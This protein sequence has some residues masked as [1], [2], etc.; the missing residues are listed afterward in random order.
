MHVHI[1][2]NLHVILCGPETIFTEPTDPSSSSVVLIQHLSTFSP[3][4]ERRPVEFSQFCPKRCLLFGVVLI[5]YSFLYKRVDFS[6]WLYTTKVQP[7]ASQIFYRKD[8]SEGSRGQTIET[9]DHTRKYQWYTN[10]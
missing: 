10:I 1:V 2:I 3:E 5:L 7:I 9:G 6:S 8:R 4:I